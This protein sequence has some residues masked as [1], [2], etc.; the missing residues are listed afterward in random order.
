[1][2]SSPPAPAL[3]GA[4]AEATGR[5]PEVTAAECRPAVL[6]GELRVSLTH[7]VR[8]L[9]LERSS[10]RITDG[11][12]ATLAALANRGPMTPTALAEDQHVQG[13]PMTR[14]VN[15]L[16][17]AGLVRRDA[18]PTDGRQVLVHI[19]EAGQAEVRETRRRR[20]EWLAKR[21]ATLDPAE[22]EVLAQASVILRT[23]IA[24]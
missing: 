20:N 7:T 23:V 16:V 5:L 19:T 15:A 22:R 18:H 11:Q 17:E 3:T 2:P 8:R 9:R 24:P 12:Y 21:L 13:P 4:G 6:A 14:T 1:M 10:E